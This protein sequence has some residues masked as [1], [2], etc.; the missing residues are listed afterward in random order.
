[1]IPSFNP[2]RSLVFWGGLLLLAFIALEWRQSTQRGVFIAHRDPIVMN[3][4]RVASSEG[5]IHFESNRLISISVPPP[6]GLLALGNPWNFGKSRSS[7]GGVAFPAFSWSSGVE[8][9]TTGFITGAVTTP[10][11]MK[12]FNRYLTVPYAYLLPGLA[13]L[14][15]LLLLFLWVKR[16]RQRVALAMLEAGDT[17]AQEPSRDGALAPG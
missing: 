13:I 12:V 10:V 8:T 2:L 4:F 11:E 17:A 6:A 9:C 7:P 14:W 3:L 5:A 16:M 15:G 1:M